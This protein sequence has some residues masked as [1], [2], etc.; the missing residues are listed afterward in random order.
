MT[1]PPSG[2]TASNVREQR[3]WYVYDWANSAYMTT[4]VTLFLGP[5]LTVLARNAAGED[6]FVYPLGI[7]V[8][9]GSYWAYLVSLSVFSQVVTLPLLGAIADYGRRKKEL[10]GFFA[11]VGAFC[12]VAMFFL[13][14]TRY[15]LGGVLFLVANLSFGASTVLCNAF[16]P[17]IAT[18]EERDAVSS[19]GWGLGYAGGGILL[20]LNLLFYSRA[21]DFGL[22]QGQAVRI[23]LASA[24]VWWAVF[25]LI[26]LMYLRNRGPR[27]ALPPG[28]SFVG[29][30]LRQL[31]ETIGDIGKY[32][33]TILFLVAFLTYNDGIQTVIML[34]SQFGQEEIKLSMS[35][36]TSV[37]LLVQFVA[38]F[39]S[40]LFN[41]IASKIGNK[42][43]VMLS[44]VIWTGTLIYIYLAVRTE[45]EFY[46]MAVFV[47][48][49]LGGSQ[50]LSR[51][52]F[53][54][55]IPAGREAEYFSLY[56]IS[57]KG[58]SW[59]GPLFFGL[60]LQFTGSYRLGILS[61]IVFFLIGLLLLSR[62][63]VARG[64]AESAG[65]SAARI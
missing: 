47:G 5:W 22:T 16:L 45:A 2:S 1:P 12:T 29:I 42:H 30:G 11:Y 62:V 4:V 33:Q 46:L 60:A 6:G 44:L 3:A 55:M 41:W 65:Q 36:L 26:P 17:E 40:L 52:I 59:L 51:S 37:V 57:D 50:A 34:A 58:T 27:K 35:T 8:H 19:K 23:S 13:D 24:G 31:R 18:P 61:L 28:A 14:G 21:A 20:A 43:A 10:L 25:T 54:L 64:I 63:N 15:L 7:R 56:E 9:P 48:L 49:V 38:F 32:P 53:S 39:G